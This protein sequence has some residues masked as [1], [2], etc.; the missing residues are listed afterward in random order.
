MI[1]SCYVL[2]NEDYIK[3][4]ES[5]EE[6]SISLNEDNRELKDTS[7]VNKENDGQFARFSDISFASGIKPLDEFAFNEKNKVVGQS[8]SVLSSNLYHPEH[9]M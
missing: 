5:L 9:R 8:K 4:S 3:L 7:T 1:L 2:C 6:D